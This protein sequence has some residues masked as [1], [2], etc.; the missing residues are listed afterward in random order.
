MFWISNW[1]TWLHLSQDQLC[2]QRVLS[3]TGEIS[4][5]DFIEV[6]DGLVFFF[7]FFFFFRWVL[8]GSGSQKICPKWNPGKWKHGLK[9][10]IPWWFHFDPTQMVLRSHFGGLGEFTTH[11]RTYF[12]GWMESDVHWGLTDL[13]FAPWPNGRLGFLSCP[14]QVGLPFASQSLMGQHEPPGI[15]P[16]IVHVSIEF[17]WKVY[18]HGD[19]SKWGLGI[20]CWGGV[21]IF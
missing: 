6:W 8:N 3:G 15:G 12:S 14:Y 21:L 5:E 16:Q 18:F 13:D 11:F 9:P 2:S 20:P 7:F 10:A 4:I 1:L 19:L 17:H